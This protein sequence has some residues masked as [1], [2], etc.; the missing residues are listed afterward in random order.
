MPWIIIIVCCTYPPPLIFPAM[1]HIL[2]LVVR[3]NL[4]QIFI[5]DDQQSFAV[6]AS[7]QW[8]AVIRIG[9]YGK[10]FCNVWQEIPCFSLMVSVDLPITAATG[11][12][13]YS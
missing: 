4:C 5:P 10:K 7:I 9:D 2:I 6:P 8:W 1:F 3:A 12:V 13:L 11:V